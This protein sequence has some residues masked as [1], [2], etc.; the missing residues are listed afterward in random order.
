MRDAAWP[1]CAPGL[2]REAGKDCAGVSQRAVRS[3]PVLS[4]VMA[5]K[6]TFV[7]LQAVSKGENCPGEHARTALD[8]CTSTIT[9]MIP[10]TLTPTIL[11]CAASSGGSQHAVRSLA[12]V[13]ANNA[14][15]ADFHP[16]VCCLE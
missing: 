8:L 16:T 6:Q 10:A 5:A 13:L 15:E 7:P 9:F 3:L 14:L 2:S 4:P 1:G 12:R 11:L